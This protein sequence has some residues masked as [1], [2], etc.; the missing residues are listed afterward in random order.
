MSIVVHPPPTHPPG[1]VYANAVTTV[2]PTY[3]REA[4]VGGA[5]G[6]L[7]SVIVQHASKFHGIVNG[8]DVSEWD[9]LTDAVLPWGFGAPGGGLDCK[10]LCKRYVRRGLGLQPEAGD[11]AIDAAA[12]TP[13]EGAA[14]LAASDPAYSERRPLVVCITRLVPQKGIHLIKH[15]I[16][17]CL[18]KGGQFVL[19][20]SSPGRRIDAEASSK[21]IARWL[22]RLHCYTASR[23]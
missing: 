8:I 12:R 19:L 22:S 11:E 18:A 4:S 16:G 14:V 10:R 2:S 1:I 21:N 17:H 15:A 7:K 5:A 23:R 20:G 13:P 6:F 9:P 3:A